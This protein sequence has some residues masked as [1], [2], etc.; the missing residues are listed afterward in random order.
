[1]AQAGVSHYFTPD[2]KAELLAL[3]WHR[4]PLT[5]P[6]LARTLGIRPLSINQF[7]DDL[8]R[9]SILRFSGDGGGGR[10]GRRAKLIDLNPEY[11]FAIGL[12]VYEQDVV[13]VCGDLK[14]TIRCAVCLPGHCLD[15]PEALLE[16]LDKAWAKVR[17]Q[18]RL[19]P[20][21]IL[22]IGLA[23]PGSVDKE[24]TT[25]LYH[26]HF[27][28][29]RHIPFK[30]HLV[31]RTG[32]EVFL[33]NDVRAAAQAEIWFGHG[34]RVRDFLYVDLGDGAALAVVLAGRVYRG[35]GFGSEWGHTT[36][37][38]RG[39]R[40]ACG[41]V[42]CLDHFLRDGYLRQ[43]LEAQAARLRC[44]LPRPPAGDSLAAWLTVPWPRADAVRA[45]VLRE[46]LDHIGVG[47]VSLV[48]T[49]NPSLI[50]IGGRFSVLGRT[51]LEHVAGMVR[52]RTFPA[53]QAE[54]DVRLSELDP[55]TAGARGAAALVL[56]AFFRRVPQIRE[57]PT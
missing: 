31:E 56:D 48:N 11:G 23:V 51:L 4:G 46:V 21:R 22:G 38:S 20:A 35:Q 29:W 47:V 50:V 25:G 57:V 15:R 5:R 2:R 17:T 37:D 33:D 12:H 3:L 9:R 8:L 30:A 6:E 49:F 7:V 32:L 45:A 19:D 53:F 42:G 28:W 24:R 36:I 18:A 55:Q 40:C 39:P 54:L 14:G 52:E 13:A 43:R 34:R 41:N 26:S 1:M 44:R 27:G 10:R 16:L